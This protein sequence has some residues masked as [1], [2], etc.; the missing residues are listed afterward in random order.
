MIQLVPA[1]ASPYVEMNMIVELCLLL[2]ILARPPDEN[3]SVVPRPILISCV[4]LLV[5]GSAPWFGVI[6]GRFGSSTNISQLLAPITSIGM[7]FLLV[8]G[9]A[10]AR[11]R[12]RQIAKEAV[13]SVEQET[14]LSASTAALDA[15]SD[16]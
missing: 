16:T 10:I 4:T 3:E 13:R 12:E 15:T 9:L 2:R 14:G 6:H 5:I 1:A 8:V 7:V 11:R